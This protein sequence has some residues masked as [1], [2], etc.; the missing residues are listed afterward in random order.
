MLTPIVIAIV[1]AIW[2]YSQYR[3]QKSYNNAQIYWE[4]SQEIDRLYQKNYG[5]SLFA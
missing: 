5:K 2:T 3:I 1:G 4:F